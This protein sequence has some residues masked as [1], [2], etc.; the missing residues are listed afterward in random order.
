ML[1]AGGCSLILL[2][3]FYFIIDVLKYQRWA[4]FFTI[5][6][7]NS[8]LIYMSVKVIDWDYASLGLFKW[9][10]QLFGENYYGVVITLAVIGVK[11]A[12]L[13]AMYHYKIFLR[14]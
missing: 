11:W 7:L 9:L 5:I 14:V 2:A 4:F 10:G 1:Y 3:I 12:F 13:R 6:G 8:I